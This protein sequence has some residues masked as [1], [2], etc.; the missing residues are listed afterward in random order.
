[1][2]AREEW[3]DARNTRAELRRSAL[4]GAASEELWNI[5]VLES[6][7]Q[8]DRQQRRE[9]GNSSSA[10]WTSLTSSTAVSC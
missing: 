10:R 5:F 9:R 3:I 1:M 8:H 7:M 6:W 2:L 4:R